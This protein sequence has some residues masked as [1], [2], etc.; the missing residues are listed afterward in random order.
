MKDLVVNFK[1]DFCCW[2]FPVK[3][4]LLITGY[5]NVISAV[6]VF[7]FIIIISSSLLLCLV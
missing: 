2:F 4:G 1:L 7:L 3:I 6:S 5:L